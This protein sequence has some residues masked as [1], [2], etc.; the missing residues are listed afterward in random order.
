M[1][2]KKILQLTFI[3][4]IHI[5]YSQ[6][7][8]NFEYGIITALSISNIS[9]SDI[10]FESKPIV[11]YKGGFFGNYYLNEKFSIRLKTLYERKGY[12]GFYRFG[13]ADIVFNMITVPITANYYFGK[14]NNWYVNL[15][16]YVGFMIAAKANRNGSVDI[17]KN[18]KSMD[19]GIS[20]GIG[21]QF[22][23]SQKTDLFIEIDNQTGMSDILKEDLWYSVKNN[24]MSL[25]LGIIL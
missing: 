21:F 16:P 1:T 4:F 9:S 22:P 10:Y 15:G 6:Q 17:T 19:F 7:K 18:Y 3:L 2:M 11:E 8:E 23:I 13:E 25:N 20:G 14:N 12:N 5:G 24:R